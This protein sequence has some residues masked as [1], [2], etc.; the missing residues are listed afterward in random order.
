MAEAKI[1]EEVEVKE[2]ETKAVETKEEVK[3]EEVKETKPQGKV[4]TDE[5]VTSL[6]E[7][8]KTNRLNR[9][10][11]EAKLRT[12]LGVGDD[13][14]IDDKKVSAYMEEK[15][16]EYQDIVSKANNRLIVAEIKTLEGYDA[17]LVERLLDFSKVEITDDGQVIGLTECVS[18]I[19]KEFPQV[20]RTA[21]IQNTGANPP[22]TEELSELQQLKRDYE[23]AVKRNDLVAVIG[24]KNQIFKLENKK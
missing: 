10:S 24:Y 12:I 23:D 19:E 6:R 16:R 3:A 14:E 20:K 21:A 1:K 11:A 13:E 17:K 2:V 7:E 9:K 5:Y 18:E 4:W 8:A 15:Q 22:Q